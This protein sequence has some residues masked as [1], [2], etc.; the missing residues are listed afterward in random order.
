MKKIFKKNK[1]HVALIEK[2]SA[3]STDASTRD[4]M[5]NLLVSHNDTID[6]KIATVKIA[7]KVDSGRF[8]TALKTMM[9]R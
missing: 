8:E 7:Q 6:D 2:A 1:K 3:K 9:K 4:A 5:R